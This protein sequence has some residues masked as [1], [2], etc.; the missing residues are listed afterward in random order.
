MTGEAVHEWLERYVEAWRTL[1]P[2]Q[3]RSLF[4][5]G[6][7]YRHSPWSEPLHGIDEVVADWLENP[8]EP[9][10]WQAQYRPHLVE[11]DLA[12]AVGQTFYDES[13]G[14]HYWNLFELRF[15]NGKCAEFTEWHMRQPS[16]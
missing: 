2:D 8:D 12:T 9:D 16:K 10:S 6:V 3:I 15:E 5:E 1:D 14:K 7:K 11:G 4:T 13:G